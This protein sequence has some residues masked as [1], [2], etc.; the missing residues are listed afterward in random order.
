MLSA[1]IVGSLAENRAGSK[2][3]AERP[4]F[5]EG[6]DG[7]VDPLPWTY[8]HKPIIVMVIG[9]LLLGT[10]SVL[11][12]LQ[13]AQVVSVSY[14][15]GTVCLSIGLIFLVT[16]LVWLPVIKQKLQRKRLAQKEHA[17]STS[18]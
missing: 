7:A 5:P 12:L 16:G 18:G 17:R 8:F 11:S 4:L 13:Y 6:D 15:M 10:G 1:G 2:H 14:T 3:K 9:G